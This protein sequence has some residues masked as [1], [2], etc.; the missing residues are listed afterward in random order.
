MPYATQ[1]DIIERYGEEELAIAADRDGDGEI[2]TEAVSRA[3]NDA[4]DEIDVYLAA[5]YELPL[6]SVPGVLKRLCVDISLYRLSADRG[7]GTEEK[8]LRYEDAIKLLKLMAE[9]TVTLGLSEEDA[10]ADQ[11]SGVEVS[12]PDRLFPH[13]IWEKY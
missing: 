5:R 10:P 4:S 8:R 6:Q 3:V 11:T 13:D 2:D 12:A 1:A 9:G 7:T